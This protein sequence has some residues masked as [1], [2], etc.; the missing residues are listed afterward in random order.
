[1]AVVTTTAIRM[2][3]YQGLGVGQN[4]GGRP[5]EDRHVADR[6]VDITQQQKPDFGHAQKNVG[7]GLDE[8]V[9]QVSGREK[10]RVADLKVA[11]QNHD[12]NDDRHHAAIASPKA[13]YLGYHFLPG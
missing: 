13:L 9:D 5:A 6:K 8:Q 4:D 12:A 3:K 7:R 11:N 10:E 1:M 2:A